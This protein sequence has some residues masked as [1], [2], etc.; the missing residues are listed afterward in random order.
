M[1]K[2]YVYI[3]LFVLIIV[4]NVLAFTI[5]KETTFE[6]KIAFVNIVY[7][8]IVY[9]VDRI[10]ESF[11]KK[12]DNKK[13]WF[14]NFILEKYIYDYCEFF[15]SGADILREAS[16]RKNKYVES[17]IGAKDL[18]EMSEKFQ[19]ELFDKFSLIKRKITSINAFIQIYDNDIYFKVQEVIE[20]YQNKFTEM[21]ENQLN[22]VNDNIEKDIIEIYEFRR[23]LLEIFYKHSIDL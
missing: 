11:D 1:K 7:L 9:F 16:D 15:D 14:K 2:G 23:K 21:L 22:N 4:I 3:A 19:Q 18:K 8:I 6:N 5:F 13:Y 10:V 20:E 17:N 12:D